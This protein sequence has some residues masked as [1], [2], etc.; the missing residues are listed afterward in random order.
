MSAVSQGA[1]ETSSETK[2]ETLRTVL[3]PGAPRLVANTF[4]T[5]VLVTFICG[6]YLDIVPSRHDLTAELYHHPPT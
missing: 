4:A 5:Y 1:A 6:I 2:Q 3:L